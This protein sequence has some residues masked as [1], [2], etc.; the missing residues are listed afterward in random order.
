MYRNR[1]QVGRESHLSPE[2]WCNGNRRSRVTSWA[3]LLAGNLR[4]TRHADDQ[5]SLPAYWSISPEQLLAELHTSASG[6]TEDDAKRRLQ[7]YGPNSLK[8]GSQVTALGL[9]LNQ[10]R[11][12]LVLILII[13]AIISA[14]VGEW[15]DAAIVLVV[16]S[17]ST[18]LDC[19]QE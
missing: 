12:P 6:L 14:V 3:K 5:M 18:T 4:V 17:G 1:G 9:L 7:Q 16:V 8:A 2:S 13:A 11:R 15:P 19:V 10:F